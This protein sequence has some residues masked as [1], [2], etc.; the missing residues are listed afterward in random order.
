MFVDT[1]CHLNM[2]VDK[3]PD[4]PL[5][6]E[7][8]PYIEQI[9]VQAHQVGVETIINVGTGINESI[10]AVAL[11]RRFAPVYATVG[12]HPEDVGQYAHQSVTIALAPLRELLVR[13][14][15]NKIVAVGEVGLDFFHKPYDKQL[16][17][18]FF[19][20]QIELALE[21]QLPL[22]IHIRDAGDD[23]LKV[24]EEY[25]HEQLRGVIHCFL[26]NESIARTVLGW[27]LYVGLDA[28]IT[29][30][31]NEAL[32]E[33]FKKLPLERILLETDAPFLPPQQYRGK[34]N[35]P[36][37]IPLIATA[38]ATLRNIDV[39]V[40]EKVTT[41]NARQLFFGENTVDAK[42]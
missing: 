12:I 34:Q 33:L 29:Y 9:V 10:N 20:A 36:A 18:D 27:G 24:L 22:T 37:Y 7:H 4:E 28:P 30:P 1:H 35:T 13:K 11:A 14:E 38:L 31:K 39:T 5:H 6:D 3:K 16:Q 25:C 42:I 23:V 40:V 26:Q 21:Y 32:R 8:F 41:V 2:M 19:K 17:I 15:E